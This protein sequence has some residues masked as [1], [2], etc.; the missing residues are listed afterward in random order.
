MFVLF[1]VPLVV[2]KGTCV[3]FILGGE[4]ANGSQGWPACCQ[5][6]QS[7][8]HWS[9]RGLSALR[10]RGVPEG[11]GGAGLS[12]QLPSALSHIRGVSLFWTVPRF[13]AVFLLTFNLHPLSFLHKQKVVPAVNMDWTIFLLKG[14]GPELQVPCELVGGYPFCLWV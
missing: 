9:L 14:P 11:I 7:S 10:G 6:M 13:C 3:F 12:R 2:F 5:G 4:K 8:G 1:N